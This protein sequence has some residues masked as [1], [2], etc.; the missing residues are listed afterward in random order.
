[1][2]GKKNR[3]AQLSS[4][5]SHSY[6]TEVFRHDVELVSYHLFIDAIL[7]LKRQAEQESMLVLNEMDVSLRELKTVCTQTVQDGVELILFKADGEGHAVGIRSRSDLL[8]GELQHG[9]QTLP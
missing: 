3:L 7:D 8:L 6:T 5:V 9:S 1:M 2:R 4:F